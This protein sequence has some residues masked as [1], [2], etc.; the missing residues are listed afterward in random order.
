MGSKT[1]AQRGRDSRWR[2]RGARHRGAVRRRRAGRGHRGR[3]GSDR[4]PARR[5]GGVW[6]WRQGHA[7]S[8]RSRRSRQCRAHGAVGGEVG[9]RRRGRLSRAPHRRP[10]PYRNPVD[11]RHARHRRAVRRTRVFDS[12]APPEGGG[13]VAVARARRQDAPGDGR[14]RRESGTVGRLHQRGHDRVPA[15]SRRHVLLP[16]DEHTTAGRASGHRDGDGRGSG[17]LADQDRAGRAVDDLARAGADAARPRD[18]VPRLRGESRPRLHA[19]RPASSERSRH[20]ADLASATT[21]ASNRASRS[22]SSTI[23]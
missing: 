15:R 23:P 3:S 16:R 13:G 21:A 14:V 11:G 9:L 18:R 2:S 7:N 5:Q 19:R 6:R 4:I 8:Q 17:A 22:P 10:A 12:A 1:A 20:P